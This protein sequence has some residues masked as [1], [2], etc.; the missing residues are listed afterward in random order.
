MDLI[1]VVILTLFLQPLV[2]GVPFEPVRVALGLMLVLFSPGY[3]LV[4]ALYPRREQLT[5]V[6]RVALGLGLSLALVPLLGLALN[7]SPWGIRL[8]P[9]VVTLSLWTLVFAAVALRQRS[10]VGQRSGLMY[11]GRPS[12][13]GS[14]S[15]GA[16]RTWP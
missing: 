15:R 9:I 2:Y 4:S 5:G 3:V 13:R 6:E 12:G 7:F 10:L 11:P 16:R 14:R 8:T 1:A